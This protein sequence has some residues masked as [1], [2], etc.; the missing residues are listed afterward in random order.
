M[1]FPV[2]DYHPCSAATSMAQRMSLFLATLLLAGCTS[3]GASGPNAGRVMGAAKTEILGTPV[4]IIEINSAVA[5]RA[6]LFAHE[7]GFSETLGESPPV[8][9]EIGPGDLVGVTVWEAPPAAL[10]GMLDTALAAGPAAISVGRNSEIAPQ[11]VDSDGRITLPFVGTLA[12]AG[13]T[14][15]EVEQMVRGRLEGIA[16]QPQVL[17]TITDNS[18]A[19]VTVVGEVATSARVPLTARG[20]R[21][22]DVIAA[23]GGV[24][25]EINKVTVQ[26]TRANT[27][28]S[29]PLERLIRNPRENVRLRPDDVVTAYFEPF[30]FI[31]LGGSGLNA[32]VP[33][34]ASGITLA[35]GLGRISGLQDSRANPRGVFIFRWEDPAALPETAALAVTGP[36]PGP[37]GTV[38]VIY[39]VDLSDPATFFAAQSFPIR[40]RDILYVSNA[41]GIDLQKFV[42]V[43]SQGA[44][45]VIGITNAIAPQN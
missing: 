45:S 23:V 32:E 6:A 2:S 42:T 36:G 1:T 33:F 4:Q 44:F 22:L 41:P 17:V 11:M 38:P 15:R 30:S 35:Q 21:I 7:R 39:R 8:G 16:N 43:L 12:V 20:E 37:E 19:N 13:R 34:Q 28:V 18:S 5:E 10:F 9:T 25:Q 27:V 40:N 31:S 26:V 3:L 24:K 29:M 14:P